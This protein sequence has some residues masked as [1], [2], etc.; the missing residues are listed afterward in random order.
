MTREEFLHVLY[1][2]GFCGCYQPE[3]ALDLIREILLIAKKDDHGF[4]E[5]EKAVEA[6]PA[7]ASHLV[8]SM[9]NDMDLLEHGGNMAMSWLGP[10]GLESLEVLNDAHFKEEM[11]DLT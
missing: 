8:L 11:G 2:S 3:E 9:L 6:N 4:H 10:E 5:Y 7:G 1:K